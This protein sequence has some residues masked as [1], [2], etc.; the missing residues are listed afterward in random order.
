MSESSTADNSSQRVSGGGSWYDSLDGMDSLDA[1]WIIV[2]APFP[3]VI[4]VGYHKSFYRFIVSVRLCLL[5][6]DS[7]DGISFFCFRRWVRMNL[8]GNIINKGGTAAMIVPDKAKPALS[9]IFLLF[10]PK[11][12]NVKLIKRSMWWEN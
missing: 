12:C 10:I 8:Y 6:A 2:A 11:I 5:V 1:K 9:G 3:Y 4:R 7:D